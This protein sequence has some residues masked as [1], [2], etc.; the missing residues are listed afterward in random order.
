MLACAN[1][2]AAPAAL[3]PRGVSRATSHRARRFSFHLRSFLLLV[4]LSVG[5]VHAASPAG[6]TILRATEWSPDDA[7]RDGAGEFEVWLCVAQLQR[8]HPTAGLVAV[9]DR[10]GVFRSGGERALRRVVFTGV[11]VVKLA[12]SGEVAATPDGLFVDA[13]TLP[14]HRAAHLLTRALERY[15]AP[16]SAANPDAPTAAECAAIRAHLQKIQLLFGREA[17]L[18]VARR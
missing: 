1:R 11:V 15:G 5:V 14:E 4:A 12:P 10:N 17:G 9:G 7:T 8:A 3:S 18:T 6:V 13:G 16:P 2:F